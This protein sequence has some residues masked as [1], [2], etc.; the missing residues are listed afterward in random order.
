MVR[1]FKPPFTERE[2]DREA[3][4]ISEEGIKIRAPP[5]TSRPRADPSS[6]ATLEVFEGF[7]S[8]KGEDQDV[9]DKVY[10]DCSFE[11]I[12]QVATGHC[13]E[14]PG[15]RADE[16]LF[17]MPDGTVFTG[18]QVASIVRDSTILE[19]KGEEMSG[20][21]A[22]SVAKSWINAFRRAAAQAGYNLAQTRGHPQLTRRQRVPPPACLTNS[23]Q[24]NNPRQ[25]CMCFLRP[26]RT[27]CEC[28]RVTTGMPDAE[29]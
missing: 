20:A 28:S 1:I 24:R 9:P 4:G 29:P 14:G 2:E 12:W 27:T 23:R 15:S 8:R 5:S 16:P 19:H 13:P 3:L 11:I 25:K 6:L 26:S 7:I 21:D 17:N 18:A 10:S 22:A